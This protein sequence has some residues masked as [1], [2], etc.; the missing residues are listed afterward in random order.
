MNPASDT[1][2]WR[3]PIAIPPGFRVWLTQPYGPTSLTAE[4]KGPN[5]EPHFHYGIDLTVG[6]EHQTYGI[7]VVCPFPTG[8]ISYEVTG[9]DPGEGG[10]FCYVVY[11]DAAG[12]EHKI[13]CYHLSEVQPVGHVA[14]GTM[15]GRIGNTGDVFP[16]PTFADP[17][18]GAHL[19]LEYYINGE[20]T[21]PLPHFD[22]N[23]PYTSSPLTPADQAPATN[24][25]IR[26]LLKFVQPFI[27]NPA[28]TS[29]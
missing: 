10:N 23:N 27:P 7:P 12:N 17:Y 19:H 28:P 5:G 22:L 1:G 29:A 6:F 4:P 2:K 11:K 16:K 26:E 18:L 24:W 13:L 8:D 21:D 9:N 14:D 15:V 3:V 20:R 25:L